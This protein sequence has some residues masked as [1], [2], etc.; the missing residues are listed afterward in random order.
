M[1]ETNLYKDR[2]Y[3]GCLHAAFEL[4]CSRFGTI[5]RATWIYA[6]LCSV[7]YGLIFLFN[8]IYVTA[9]S[10]IV[11][12]VS[13][14]LTASRVVTLLND[15]HFSHNV[16]HCFKVGLFN[17]FG[18]VFYMCLAAGIIY[19]ILHFSGVTVITNN[20]YGYII[21][22]SVLFLV[23]CIL[24]VFA[25]PLAYSETHYLIEADSS[26]AGI[27]GRP[28]RHGF[29]NWG[30]LAVVYILTAI[31]QSILSIVLFL[32]YVVLLMAMQTDA[33]GV[34]LGDASGLPGSFSILLFG[35][36][37]LTSFIWVY[38]ATWNG[39]V[40]YYAYGRIE[41]RSKTKVDDNNEKSI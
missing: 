5:M 36:C 10:I 13:G 18:T 30:F 25:I 38:L 20:A 34:A 32:P 4:M 23:G 29:R 19:C 31:I 24:F 11:M 22:F 6:L 17:V 3:T 12:F 40:F 14:V 39:L 26:F 7:G 16:R 2:G 8:N 28:Y 15:R 9:I 21:S 1:I 41:S 35:V 37:V 27:F 33:R